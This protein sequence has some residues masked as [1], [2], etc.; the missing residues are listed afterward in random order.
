MLIID[1]REKSNLSKLII[2]RA[3]KKNIPN[4][5][6]WL[7]VGDYVIG[8]VCF[9]AKSASDFMGSVINK[10][11][12]TQLDNMD[13]CYKRN[14]VVIYGTVNDALKVTKYM[15]NA[16]EGYK[17][18]LRNQFI[19]AIGRIRLDYDVGIIWRNN[20]I[21]VVD[22]IITI[23]KMAPIK[24]QVIE[25]SLLKR[26]ATNDVRIDILTSIKGVSRK[27]AKLL[28][29]EYG[30]IMEIGD[31]GV[32]ELMKIEGIGKVIADRIGAVLNSEKKV[33]Q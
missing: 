19:G 23:A 6:K 8:D 28:L 25:P 12:W 30:S 27:K 22:E 20:V 26:V 17:E 9:E 3:N 13:R 24:R 21:D 16:G 33:K 10:R 32:E 31:C 29:K 5:K 18:L 15:K 1:S 7:E 4:E 11:I 2:N 14:F